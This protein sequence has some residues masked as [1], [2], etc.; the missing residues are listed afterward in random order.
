MQEQ[1]NKDRQ[2]LPYNTLNG[3]GSNGAKR[4]LGHRTPA[5]IRTAKKRRTRRRVIMASYVSPEVREKFETLSVDLKN[6]IL[7]RDVRLENIHDLIRV[8]EEI[9]ADN[10]VN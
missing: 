6:M 10:E 3:P 5:G 7:E 4:N 9:V 1:T 2:E 8:L